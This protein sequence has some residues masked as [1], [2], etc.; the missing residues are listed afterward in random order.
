MIEGGKGRKTSVK[1]ASVTLD[2]ILTSDQ[3]DAGLN[4]DVR[5]VCRIKFEPFP[6]DFRSRT[7]DCKR[8]FQQVAPTASSQPGAGP[9]NYGRWV[10]G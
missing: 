4:I 7:V 3:R 2:L 10:D 9:S 1:L 5:W 8:W 6:V